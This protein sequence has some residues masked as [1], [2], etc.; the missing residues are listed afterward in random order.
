MHHVALALLVLVVVV[1][2]GFIAR[3][4]SSTLK[5]LVRDTNEDYD[6]ATS[7]S[8]LE[9]CSALGRLASHSRPRQI[10]PTSLARPSWSRVVGFV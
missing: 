2:S 8:Q 10:L 5:V 7:T 9:G 3:T 1:V 4:L 6:N